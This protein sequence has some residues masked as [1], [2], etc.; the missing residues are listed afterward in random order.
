MVRF[1]ERDA[2]VACK[3]IK[4]HRAYDG[5]QGANYVLSEV[6]DPVRTMRIAAPLAVGLVTVS[7]LV[8]NLAYLAVISKTDILSGGR[9]VGYASHPHFESTFCYS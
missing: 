7:Y 3:L 9:M 8:V 4:A 1:P 6:R 5:Y 2:R